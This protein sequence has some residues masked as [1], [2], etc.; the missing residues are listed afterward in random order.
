[1]KTAVSIPDEVFASAD[2][3]AEELGVSR[4]ELYARAVAE[5]V[6]KHQGA[7]ITARLNQVYAAESEEDLDDE[8]R[9][10]QARSIAEEEC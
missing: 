1:M 3:L 5:Y 9:R 6:A 10:A 7:E 8:L 2:A 4:S